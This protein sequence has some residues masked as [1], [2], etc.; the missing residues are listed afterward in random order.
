[1]V[2]RWVD[3][4]RS[5]LRSHDPDV[6]GQLQNRQAD[7]WRPLISIADTIGGKWPSIARQAAIAL[8]ADKGDASPAVAL[9]EDFQA[10]FAERGAVWVSSLDVVE[11]LA[12]LEDRPWPEYKQG[13]AIS[14]IQVARLLSGF[15]IWPQKKKQPNKSVIRG[16]AKN[17]FSD[18]W[19]RYLA[20]HGALTR[21]PATN[22]GNPGLSEDFNPL[23]DNDEVAGQNSEKWRFSADGG[24]VATRTGVDDA[25]DLDA[26]ATGTHGA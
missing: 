6:P 11:H 10:F 5:S 26:F 21:Y 4:N 7:N 14:S 19:D 8:S 23:P 18:A 25:F 17:Q 13:R 3:D 16:Y 15:N 12:T 20:S 9:L 22:G 2:A 1:M 24:G